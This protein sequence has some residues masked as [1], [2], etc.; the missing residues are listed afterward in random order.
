MRWSRL[1]SRLA[2]VC[3]FLGVTGFS[4]AQ[5]N[6]LIEGG[7]RV[8]V[9]YDRRAEKDT[10]PEEAKACDLVQQVKA[11]TQLKTELNRTGTF[12][13]PISERGLY[14]TLAIFSRTVPASVDEPLSVLLKQAD[15]GLS[16]A[17]EKNFRYT[18]Y[19]SSK[20]GVFGVFL[21]LTKDLPDDQ[22]RDDSINAVCKLGSAAK[23]SKVLLGVT[24]A[25]IEQDGN[26]VPNPQLTA[27]GIEKDDETVVIYY[28]RLEVVQR[29]KFTKEKPLAAEDVNTVLSTIDARL[30]KRK[31]K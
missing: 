11:R 4:V 14:P 13:C 1:S 17:D 6:Q 26:V 31:K 28:E 21:T 20:L 10:I 8:Y 15:E 23:F 3:L 12:L 27:L 24:E 30:V 7:L 5:D 16:N 22:K 19:R 9:V 25:Q 29:W 18:D 2:F